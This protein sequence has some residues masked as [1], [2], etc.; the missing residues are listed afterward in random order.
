MTAR[1]IEMQVGGDQTIDVADAEIN[2]FELPCYEILFIEVGL[3]VTGEISKMAFG[4]VEHSG[5][6]A[7]VE[8]NLALRMIDQ[9]A[10]HWNADLSALTFQQQPERRRQPAAGHRM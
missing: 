10:R 4:I 3:E 1:V 5:V 8:Q 7:T 2:S 9:V 6:E